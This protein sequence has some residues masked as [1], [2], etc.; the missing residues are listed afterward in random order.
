[1]FA[2]WVQSYISYNLFFCTLDE[3]LDLLLVSCMMMPRIPAL[4]RKNDR[5]EAH[6]PGT[7]VE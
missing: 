4:T 2:V 7:K 6:S 5:P 3:L 1:M